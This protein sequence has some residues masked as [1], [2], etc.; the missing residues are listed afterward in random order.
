[1]KLIMKGLLTQTFGTYGKDLFIHWS[2]AYGIELQE[3]MGAN[4]MTQ[5]T[6][7]YLGNY[8]WKNFFKNIFTKVFKKQNLEF[9]N[10]QLC[11]GLCKRFQ[12]I[13]HLKKCWNPFINLIF[14]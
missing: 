7:A 12:E 9:F 1:M 4:G 14:A 2:Y 11:Q 8:F 10:I 6:V 3:R 5:A 13:C